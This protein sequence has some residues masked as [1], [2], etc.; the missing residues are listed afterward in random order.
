MLSDSSPIPQTV[1]PDSAAARILEGIT[2]AFFALDSEWRFT[3]VN[4]QAE[5][6]LARPRAELVGQV[7]WEEFPAAVGSVFEQEYRHAASTQ[8][9]ASF[10]AFFPPL[11]LWFEV[12]AFPA[13]GGLSVFFHDITESAERRQR[14]EF[15][16]ALADRAR[17]FTTPGE[18]IDDALRSVGEFLGVSRCVFVDIDV[19]ADTCTTQPDY[20]A[21]DTIASMAGVFPISSF[22]DIVGAAYAAGKSVVVSDVR[23][24]PAQVPPESIPTYD[25]LGIR[26]HVGVPVVHSDRLVSCIGVHST[27]PRLWKPEEVA[28][29]QTVVD[30]TWLTVEVARQASSLRRE[31]EATARILESITDAFV[32]YDAEWRFTYINDQ[33]EKIMARTRA[34]LLGRPFWEMFPEAVGTVFEREYRRAVREQ[35]PVTF[36]EFYVP[37]DMWLEVRAYPSADGGLSVFYQDVSS[38]KPLRRNGSEYLHGSATLPPSFRKPSSRPCRKQC[39]AWKSP[40]LP[41]PPCRKPRSAATFLTSS[42]SI[43]N[44]MR[45]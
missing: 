44:C 22:G 21:D 11:N 35:V 39:R 19:Q 23:T 15:L 40:R 1:L 14:E 7:V 31:A 28:L 12:R 27:A 4:A 9:A 18:V 43:K 42:R 41:A 30:R 29:L 3:Y 36:E 5:R 24:D 37:L 45:S 8:T 6:L 2:D 25:A 13:D 26:A 20:R 32:A 17:W 33:S 34:E 16:A 38:G 10:E